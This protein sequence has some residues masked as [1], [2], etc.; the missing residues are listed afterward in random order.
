MRVWNFNGC[1]PGGIKRKWVELFQLQFQK[2]DK[3]HCSSLQIRSYNK[4]GMNNV[5]TILTPDQGV[6]SYACMTIP[7]QINFIMYLQMPHV[8]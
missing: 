6:V 8:H 7:E 2:F 5:P 3:L 4:E 1:F